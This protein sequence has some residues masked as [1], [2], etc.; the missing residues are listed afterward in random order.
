MK[1]GMSSGKR[2]FD[3]IKKNFPM[4]HN[5]KKFEADIQTTGEAIYTNDFPKQ[6]DELYAAFVLTT[7]ANGKILEIDSTNAL[8][9]FD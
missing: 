7:Q 4:N 3:T 1:R 8:V 2:E 9:S 5:V 6:F